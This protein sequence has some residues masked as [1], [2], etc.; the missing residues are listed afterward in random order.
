VPFIFF[1]AYLMVKI[2]LKNGSLLLRISALYT[3]RKANSVQTLGNQ[4]VLPSGSDSQFS[5][6][7]KGNSFCSLSVIKLALEKCSLCSDTVGKLLLL[8]KY[9]FLGYRNALT[10]LRKLLK[11]DYLR[12]NFRGRKLNSKYQSFSTISS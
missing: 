2:Q 10:S 3:L 8:K 5:S 11:V 4:K 12:L 6:A 9:D 7:P 1:Q